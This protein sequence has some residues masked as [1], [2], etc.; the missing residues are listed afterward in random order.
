[1][2]PEPEDVA[3][4]GADVEGEAGPTLNAA[5]GVFADLLARATR[6]NE[7]LFGRPGWNLIADVCNGLWQLPRLDAQT[8]LCAELEDGQRLNGAGDKWFGAGQG[9]AAVREMI[10]KVRAL[11]AVHA[12]AVLWAARW[13]WGHHEKINAERDEWW[14]LAARRTKPV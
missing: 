8:Q 6:D 3:V 1:V 4:L 12:W 9:D 2:Y 11:D 10:G 14:T 13:F 7:R 5:L